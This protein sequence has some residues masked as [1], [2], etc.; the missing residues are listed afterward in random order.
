TLGDVEIVDCLL[1]PRLGTAA[2]VDVQGHTGNIG[3][4]DGPHRVVES[5]HA[6]ESSN[7]NAPRGCAFLDICD[8]A[9]GVRVRH[10]GDVVDSYVGREHVRTLRGCR[11]GD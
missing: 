2:P 11:G 7:D 8:S 10:G 4:G 1:Q 6:R 3:V 5:F 9:T